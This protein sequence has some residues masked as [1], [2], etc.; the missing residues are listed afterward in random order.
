MINDQTMMLATPDGSFEIRSPAAVDAA[1]I[2]ELVEKTPVLD[3]NS[4]YAYLLLCTHFSETG[5]VARIAGRLVGFALGYARP[6]EGATVFVWQVAVADEARGRGLGGR[7]LDAC[8][9]RCARRTDARFLEATVTPSN[10]AS[11]A[12]FT[13]FARRHCAPIQRRL[14]FPKLVFPDHVPHEEETTIRIGPVPLA[15]AIYHHE[16]TS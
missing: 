1:A 4:P 7:M 13:S 8:F 5:V 16:E 6:D 3:S 11:L 12:L 9:A 10:E 14:A 15:R 2:W